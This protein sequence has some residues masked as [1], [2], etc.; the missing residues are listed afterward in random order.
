M[1]VSTDPGAKA[2]TRIPCDGELRG[3]GPRK[4]TIAALAAE[5]N[6]TRRRIDESTGGHHVEID[7]L[8]HSLRRCGSA[9]LDRNTVTLQV[10]REG[11]STTLRE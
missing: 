11:T 4:D 5:Y 1:S 7:A 8:P 9:G 3:H 10:D 2:S 6:S